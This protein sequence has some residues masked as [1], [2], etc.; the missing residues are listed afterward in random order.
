MPQELE[1]LVQSL[2][3]KAY[4]GR[5]LFEQIH[6]RSAA[7]LAEVSVLPSALRERLASDGWD[8]HALSVARERRSSDGTLKMA[9]AAA[10]GAVVESVL[11]GMDTG[12]YTQCLSSQV[13]CAL[14]CDFCVTGTLG[15]TRNMTPAEI[16]DQYLLARGRHP[17][18][19]VRNLV[20]MGMGEPLNNFDNVAT[21]IRILQE[22]RGS[23]ISPRRITVSTAGIVPGIERLGREVDALLAV[24]LNAPRQ[25]LREQLM[26]IARRY[27][28]DVLMAAL[29][30]F[31][32]DPRRRLTF[33]YVLLH[34]VNDSAR[35]ARDL[36]RLLSHVR[37]K[38]NL[39]PYNPVAERE[40]LRPSEADVQA[41]ADILAG[42]HMTVT[43]RKSKG[44]DIEAAC[45][46]LA[47]TLSGP[48]GAGRS[49]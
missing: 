38:V 8:V 43:V 4:R 21:A 39:I 42:K 3:E 6:A 10:D 37:C 14:A 30:A 12:S 41:F 5:Q 9:L 48:P 36:V 7:S 1:Q 33:E 45:G 16:V 13:G 47:G 35:D 29:K 20:F 17:D 34:G 44:Q 49:V 26:P 24:S 25:D 28:L 40:A 15:F 18:M 19:P 27:P 11:I 22:P 32:L 2:G 46:Q 31:P 23:N